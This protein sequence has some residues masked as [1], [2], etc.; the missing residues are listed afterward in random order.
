MPGCIGPSDARVRAKVVAGLL[1]STEP[2]P[3]AFDTNALEQRQPAVEP[4]GEKISSKN[5]A[6]SSR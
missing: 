5:T 6:K 3:Q 2:K 4:H 1:P